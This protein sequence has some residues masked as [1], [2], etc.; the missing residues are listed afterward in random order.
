[1]T[2]DRGWNGLKFNFERKLPF[3]FQYEKKIIKVRVFQ[4]PSNK[5]WIIITHILNKLDC[6]K[7]VKETA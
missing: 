5:I 3:H 4:N 7:M 6:F 1:L 2:P